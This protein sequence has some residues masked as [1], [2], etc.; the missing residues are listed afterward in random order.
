MSS[1][2]IVNDEVYSRSA[3][4]ATATD[5]TPRELHSAASAVSWGAIFAGAAAAAAL[6]LVLLV[7]GSGLGLSS[8]SPWASSGIRGSTLGWSAILW[9]MLTQVAA[10]GLGGYL[11]GRLRSRWLVAHRDEVYFRDTAHGFLAW[12]V[13]TLVT[14]ALLASAVST[15]VGSGA[16]LAGGAVAA[17]AG[18]VKPEDANASFSYYIDKALRKDVS[19]V[20]VPTEITTASSDAPPVVAKPPQAELAPVPAG[21][22][23]L[24][25]FAHSIQA[26][27]MSDE[28]L[29]YAGQ[30]VA[31]RT[32]MTQAQ[33][34]ARVSAAYAEAQAALRNAE[35]S[36]K[37]A[38]DAARKASA[39]TAL[40][41][42]I[43]LM[44]GAFFASL[45]ATFGGSQRDA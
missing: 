17:G 32:G 36:T 7:L 41:L 12:A 9:V 29:R 44:M 33:A 22:E 28:D 25:L 42:V 20:A 15:V 34:Q 30:W 39:Y 6:S 18:T 43:G 31:Q 45:A 1:P 14:A 13:A 26:G 19:S 23:M 38:A 11:A 35:T 2:P 27:A 5:H 3:G 8:V 24:R 21:P 37:E 40:W 10:A 16:S 4:R